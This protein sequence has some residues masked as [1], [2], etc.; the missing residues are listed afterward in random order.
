MKMFKFAKGR[1]LLTAALSASY[2]ALP[3][4]AD[5]AGTW[6][7]REGVGT[8]GIDWTSWSESLELL[9]IVEN[10]GQATSVFY[11]RSGSWCSG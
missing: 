8:G 9:Q 1:G 10:R 7:K 5:S 6:V 2:L 11:N 3:L 4:F